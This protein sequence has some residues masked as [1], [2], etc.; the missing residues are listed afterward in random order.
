MAEQTL[1]NRLS[2]P[3]SGC[4][5]GQDQGSVLHCNQVTKAAYLA[6]GMDLNGL[7]GVLELWI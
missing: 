6:I 1:G 2:H 3:V 4:P 7:K 5:D